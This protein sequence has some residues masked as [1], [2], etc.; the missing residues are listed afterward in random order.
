VVTSSGFVVVHWLAWYFPA[1]NKC[2]KFTPFVSLTA[3]DALRAPLGRALVGESG[4]EFG[5]VITNW[6]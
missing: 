3:Q 6:N 1:S 2:P 5:G 4:K